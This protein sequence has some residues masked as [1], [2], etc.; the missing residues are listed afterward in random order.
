MVLRTD[1]VQNRYESSEEWT[2]VRSVAN[3]LESHLKTK[4]IRDRVAEANQPGVS[5]SAVQSI[6]LEHATRIGFRDEARGLFKNYTNKGLRPDYY[7]EIGE[8]G[9][10]LEIERGKT[11]QNNMDFLDFWKCHICE[12]AHYLFLMVPREL[13]QN[14]G[15]SVSRPYEVTRSHLAALFEPRNYTNVRGLVLYGY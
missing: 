10:I 12:H 15:G 6:L 2:K 14:S 11:N 1:F 4:M 8:S 9:I 3:Q 7:L 13:K 5:S